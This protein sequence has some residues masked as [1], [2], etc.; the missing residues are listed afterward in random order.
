LDT[1]I[2]CDGYVLDNETTRRAVGA[3]TR[4]LNGY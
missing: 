2:L 1:P 4:Q 3:K